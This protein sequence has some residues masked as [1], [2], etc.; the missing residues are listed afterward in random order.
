MSLFFSIKRT[1]DNLCKSIGLCVTENSWTVFRA[2]EGSEVSNICS[3]DFTLSKSQCLN[4][5]VE[6]FFLP[7]E[8]KA[9]TQLQNRFSFALRLVNCKQKPREILLTVLSS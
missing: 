2:V 7:F 4:S 1:C 6:D 9:L 3:L 5:W 8:L